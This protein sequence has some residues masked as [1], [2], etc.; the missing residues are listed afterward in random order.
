L[1]EAKLILLCYGRGVAIDFYVF[2]VEFEG[3]DEEAYT[4]IFSDIGLNASYALMDYDFE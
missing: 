1:D 2:R 4:R 3:I